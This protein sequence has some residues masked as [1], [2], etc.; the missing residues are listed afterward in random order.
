MVR[1]MELYEYVEVTI[2][3]GDQLSLIKSNT[4]TAY[5]HF[6]HLM[7]KSKGVFQ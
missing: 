6:S 2:Y 4:C 7:Q 5:N 1:A 3:L